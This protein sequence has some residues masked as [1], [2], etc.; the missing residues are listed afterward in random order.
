[1]RFSKDITDSTPRSLL[2][3]ISDNYDISYAS[4]SLIFVA[5]G[6]GHLVATPQAYFVVQKVGRIGGRT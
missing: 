3:Y 6:L 4:V 5:N 2:P 1:M